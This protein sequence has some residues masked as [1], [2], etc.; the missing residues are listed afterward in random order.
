MAS[1][2]WTNRGKTI[3]SAQYGGVDL[4]KDIPRFVRLMERGLYDAG[5]IATATFPLEKS[6]EAFQA[7]AD[8]TT[9]SAHVVFV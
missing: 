6:R 9:V 3:H 4:M 1:G 2:A 7:A 8:R 5:S